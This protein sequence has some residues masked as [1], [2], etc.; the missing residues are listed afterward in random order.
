M[1]S[2]QQQQPPNANANG[3]RTLTGRISA[4]SASLRMHGLRTQEDED[5][6]GQDEP[7]AWAET[8]TL[9]GEC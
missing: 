8:S 3:R 7:G 6:V 4:L 2:S 1:P 5:E 9:V